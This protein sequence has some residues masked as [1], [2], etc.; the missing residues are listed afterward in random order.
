MLLFYVVAVVAAAVAGYS[1]F[2]AET[3]NKHLAQ[4][5][6]DSVSSSAVENAVA[7]ASDA[8]KDVA[9][10]T[11]EGAKSL[12][13]AAVCHYFCGCCPCV[14]TSTPDA[15]SVDADD[16]EG[17]GMAGIQSFPIYQKVSE[18]YI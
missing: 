6:S 4:T 17:V 14:G 11:L 15:P 9:T 12:V 7:A 2:P 8:A 10:D 18:P 1:A 5:L 13:R 16:V 3:I